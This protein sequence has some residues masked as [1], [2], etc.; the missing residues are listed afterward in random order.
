MQR[1]HLPVLLKESLSSLNVRPGGI[2][3][4][5]TLGNGGHA[6]GIL[7]ESSPDGRLIGIDRDPDAIPRVSERLHSFGSRA[8]AVTGNF[9]NV[10]ALVRGVGIEAVDGVL[11]DLGVSM[12][13]LTD[14]SRG[15]SFVSDAP[16][17]MRM[18]SSEPV[19]TAYD[20]VNHADRDQLRRI[21]VEYGE[22]KRWGAIVNAIL[23]QREMRPIRTA[24]ELAQLVEG[25]LPGARRYR[26]HPATRTFQAL[27]IAVNDE[28]HAL[29]DG[30][31]GAVNLLVPG[32][33]VAVI[34]FHSLEDRIVKHYFRDM[35]KGCTCPDDFPVCACGKT[36]VLRRIQRKPVTPS[37]EEI[38]RNPSAR[39]A[40]LR[41]AEAI[42]ERE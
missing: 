7:I 23:R 20:L 37:A 10:E 34:S 41:T 30:L 27:R 12:I 17:D 22:E 5:C 32:G 28:L 24:R 40:K 3:V 15:F 18:N 26:I 42:Q 25:A 8:L 29:K 13:Q 19:P 38:E 36:P 35:E 6:E 4:D 11:M 9:R 31:E 39:S 16:L 21:L 2:Y 1:N 33:R 14:P